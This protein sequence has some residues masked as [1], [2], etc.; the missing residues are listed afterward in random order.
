MSSI[1]K[2]LAYGLHLYGQICTSQRAMEIGRTAYALH[3]AAS[4]MYMISGDYLQQGSSRIQ[5]IAR[6]QNLPPLIIAHYVFAPPPE[7]VH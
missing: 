5:K 3:C 4:H 2:T 6:T 1:G 7:P